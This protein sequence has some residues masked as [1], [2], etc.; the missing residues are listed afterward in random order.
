[1]AASN[2]P[3]TGVRSTSTCTRLTGGKNR[4]DLR[5]DRGHPRPDGR[6]SGRRC[7]QQSTRRAMSVPH[8]MKTDEAVR[9]L[10]KGRRELASSIAI[11]SPVAMVSM[12]SP[13]QSDSADCLKIFERVYPFGWLGISPTHRRST[14]N[15]ST[16]AMNGVSPCAACDRK[17]APAITCKC[18]LTK[19]SKTGPI[20]ASGMNSKSRLPASAGAKLVT[21]PSIEKSIAPLRSFVVEPMQYGRMFLIGDAAHIVPPTGAKGLNLGGQ[22]RQYAVQHPAQGLPR[23]SPRFAGKILAD[24][25][26]PGVES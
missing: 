10:R 18:R 4:D 2:W 1:M 3:W 26:T 12:A 25:P 17:P 9:D 7:A 20:N 21:G 13:G 11:T 15:W 23:R 24:L 8:G 19:R 6:S 16:P 22:R 5:P 14:K